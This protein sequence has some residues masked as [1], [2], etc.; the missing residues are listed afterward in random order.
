MKAWIEDGFL[1]QSYGGVDAGWLPDTSRQVESLKGPTLGDQAHHA[2]AQLPQLRVITARR[3][4]GSQVARS[5]PA[6]IAHRVCQYDLTVP[7]HAMPGRAH[8]AM[9]ACTSRLFANSRVWRVASWRGRPCSALVSTPGEAAKRRRVRTC[10]ARG[11]IRVR[12]LYLM[13][14]RGLGFGLHCCI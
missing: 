2:V 7:Y 1:I 12:T 10:R 11:R 13:R 14:V 5:V 6:Q 8:I 4:T 9:A 3:G